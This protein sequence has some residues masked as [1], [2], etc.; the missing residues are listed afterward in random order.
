VLFELGAY[1]LFRKDPLVAWRFLRLWMPAAVRVLALAST[2]DRLNSQVTNIIDY[3]EGD[4][5]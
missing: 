2:L 4:R 5:P 1:K 3:Y